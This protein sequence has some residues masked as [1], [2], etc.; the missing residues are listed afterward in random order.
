MKKNTFVKN[1]KLQIKCST[2]IIFFSNSP[3]NQIIGFLTSKRPPS[4]F[5]RHAEGFLKGGNAGNQGSL[6]K[7]LRLFIH[8]M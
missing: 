3:P 8:K 5:V 6:Q 4:P 1:K 2:E 7:K